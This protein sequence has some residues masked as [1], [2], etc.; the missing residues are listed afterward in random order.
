MRL[1]HELIGRAEAMVMVVVVAAV[2]GAAAIVEI[3]IVVN[4]SRAGN[5]QAKLK[6]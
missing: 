4:A 1:S 2:T 5:N 3:E 6:G